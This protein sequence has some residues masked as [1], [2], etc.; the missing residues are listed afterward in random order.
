MEKY[1]EEM[2]WDYNSC[3]I[4]VCIP[5]HNSSEK[6]KEDT[7]SKYGC[8]HQRNQICRRSHVFLFLL[9]IIICVPIPILK[10]ES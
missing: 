2:K 6:R 7:L 1:S 8:P 10:P 3:T 9:F 5:L 4:K